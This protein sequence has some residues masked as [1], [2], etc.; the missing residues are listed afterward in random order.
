MYISEVGSKNVVRQE[1]IK[2]ARLRL[3]SD[4]LAVPTGTTDAIV[5]ASRFVILG[6]ICAARSLTLYTPASM[7][8]DRPPLQSPYTIRRGRDRCESNLRRR[9]P[10]LHTRSCQRILKTPLSS[11]YECA[12]PVRKSRKLCRL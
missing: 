8:L 6:L 4:Y 11:E 5:S 10:L 7:A 12:V 1:H 9:T 3:F 2:R